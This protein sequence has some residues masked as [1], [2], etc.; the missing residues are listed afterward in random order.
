[1][2]AQMTASPFDEYTGVF[3]QTR[4]A[5][6]VNDRAVPNASAHLL[7]PVDDVATALRDL[8]PGE[9]VI[10]GAG[11]GLRE[12]A[13]REPIAAGHKLALRALAA[14]L[15]IRKYGEYIG[16]T[17]CDIPAGAW[18]HEHNLATT[19]RRTADM[20]RAWDDAEPA[21]IVGVPGN[22]R[23]ALGESPVWRESDGCLW[24][25]DLRDTP[26]IHALDPATGRERRWPM[27]ED[28]GCIVPCDDGT[29]IAGLRSGFAVFDPCTGAL[30]P[31]VDPEP[32]LSHNRLNDG[33]CDAQGRLWCAS[34]NPDSGLAEGTLYA[35]DG[36][37][38]RAVLAGWLTPNGMA[39]SPDGATFYMADSRRGTID[40]FDFDGGRGTL[41][42]RRVFADLAAL[43]GGP[44]GAT[45]DREGCLWSASFD[46]GCLLR[47]DPRG[48]IDRVVR[49][50][51]SKP[52]SCAFGGPDY[53][54]LFVTTA[55]RALSPARLAAEPLA[56]RVLALDVGVAGLPAHAFSA[57]HRARNAAR[58]VE[59]DP[60]APR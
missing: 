29:F 6:I 26:A 9:Q 40:A 60:A 37:D 35:L 46:G 13:V 48:R 18:V 17:T 50:P 52:A 53:R 24:Y 19:A 45:V 49:L 54:T 16:R 30:Q 28:I 51:V 23:C 7:D 1:M 39:W 27:A 36:N 47:L 58:A 14:G 31:L 33:K 43:P 56:G 44:D 41:S 22:V 8:V 11:A 38:C 2:S 21:R 42:R 34:M 15:R 10:V 4:Q 32:A 20:A 12:V 57:R 25:V 3:D 5:H 59:D 55:S